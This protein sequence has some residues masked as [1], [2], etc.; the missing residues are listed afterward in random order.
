MLAAGLAFGV[1]SLVEGLTPANAY[2][3]FLAAA[4]VVGWAEST[5]YAALVATLQSTVPPQM[6]GRLFSIQDGLA[7]AMAPLGL[8]VVG[9]VADVT[10]LQ[11]P[12]VMRGLVTLLVVITWAATPSVRNLEDG[13]PKQIVGEDGDQKGSPGDTSALCS[14]AGIAPRSGRGWCGPAR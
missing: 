6:Q 10:G 1:A 3:L 12:F 2:W 11:A 13:P 4:L 7:S 5:F 14:S 9:Q 8:A